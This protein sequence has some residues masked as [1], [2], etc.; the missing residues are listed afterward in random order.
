MLFTGG[1]AAQGRGALLVRGG[2]RGPA[3]PTGRACGRGG[4]H[5]CSR[6]ARRD[7]RGAPPCGASMA[8]SSRSRFVGGADSALLR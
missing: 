8:L 2:G 6:C 4:A 5:A 1:A 7:L 3:V